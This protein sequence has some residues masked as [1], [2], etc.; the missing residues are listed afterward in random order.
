[1]ISPPFINCLN[2]C[3]FFYFKQS[4]KQALLILKVQEFISAIRK[5]SSNDLLKKPPK[6][7]LMKQS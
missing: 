2:F 4:K 1:M 5:N 3:L 6:G 7:S